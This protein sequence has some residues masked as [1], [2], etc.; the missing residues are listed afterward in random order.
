M[1]G[2]P[3]VLRRPLLGLLA[4][5]ALAACSSTP[6]A[7]APVAAATAAAA[8]APERAWPY[9]QAGVHPALHLVGDSTMADK[10]PLPVFPERG[11]GQLLREFMQEPARLVN[12]AANGRS[13][14]RF[15]DEGRWAHLLTQL[16]A[17]DFVI[18]QF[19][20]N[21][22][23]DDDPRRYAPAQTDFKA[24]LRSFI[25]D[26]LAK[27]ATPILATSVARRKFGKD[28]RVV[29]TL[30]DYPQAL[31]D[32]AAETGVAL[33]D[34]NVLTTEQIQA[35][36]PEASKALFMHI[37][38]GRYDALPQGRVDDTHY[39]EEGAR[40]TAALAVQAL[41]Q[42]VPALRPWFKAL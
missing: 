33:I 32:V 27:G 16:T 12:H 10:P 38:P 31:R 20:H 17:G 4:S 41:R 34:M 7:A 42:Q 30:A 21:D 23:K 39:V 19:G 15:V 22:Q 3:G 14:R 9:P 11:W 25:A 18:I 37:P 8:S 24:F 26:V 2:E 13:T 1:T 40:A 28:G 29:Q 36:G 6:P 5:A 35:L